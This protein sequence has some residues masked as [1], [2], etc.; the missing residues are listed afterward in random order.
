MKVRIVPVGCYYE[1]EVKEGLFWKTI[2][3]GCFPLRVNRNQAIK[4]ANEYMYR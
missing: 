2:Y 4:I 3:D 1:I